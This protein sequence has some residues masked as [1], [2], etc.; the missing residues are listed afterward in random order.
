MTTGTL[1]AM[2]ARTRELDR[3]F[4]FDRHASAPTSSKTPSDRV[5]RFHLPRTLTTCFT[6]Q[7]ATLPDALASLGV[8]ATR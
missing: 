3:E 1:I 5:V 2:V 7:I 8:D 6:T 4:E